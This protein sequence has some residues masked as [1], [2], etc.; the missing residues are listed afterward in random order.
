MN[1]ARPNK[2][3][4]IADNTFKRAPNLRYRQGQDSK[5]QQMHGSRRLLSPPKSLLSGR[6]NPVD[7][8]CLERM[9]NELREPA[10]ADG[11]RPLS[12][13]THPIYVFLGGPPTGKGENPIT[14]RI[15]LE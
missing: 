13:T 2:N 3:G 7:K 12:A 15:D 10:C 9:Q 4:P 8:T 11:A 14:L 6:A 1:G 5:E